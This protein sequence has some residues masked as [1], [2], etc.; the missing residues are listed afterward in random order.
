MNSSALRFV[1]FIGFAWLV[2]FTTCLSS[3]HDLS[4]QSS[5]DADQSWERLRLLFV[6]EAELPA[7]L[8]GPN[9]R[10]VLEAA[11]VAELLEK[12]RR[13]RADAAEKP[14]RDFR[15]Q[16]PDSFVWERA[17]YEVE[18]D[19]EVGRLNGHALGNSFSDGLISLPIPW[20]QGLVHQLVQNGSPPVWHRTADGQV[21]LLL[22]EG[23][24][25]QFQVEMTIPVSSDTVRQTV[26]LHL[27]TV[28]VASLSVRVAG[29]V[30]LV[31]GAAVIDRRYDE[32]DHA[33]Y[34]QLAA[35]SGACELVFTLNNRQ[36]QQTLIWDSRALILADVSRNLDR[37]QIVVE[38]QILQGQLNQ[39]DWQ[40]TEDWEVSQVTGEGVRQWQVIRE[41]QGPRLQVWF[42]NGQATKPFQVF[43]FRQRT[44]SQ[45][46]AWESPTWVAST[47][48][49]QPRVIEITTTDDLLVPR[50]ERT[51][52]D[53]VPASIAANLRQPFQVNNDATLVRHGSWYGTGSDAQVRLTLRAAEDLFTTKSS[54]YMLLSP[55][56]VESRTVF[57][58]E[59]QG[60][61]RFDV[62]LNLP[63]GFRVQS[64][65]DAQ[66]N[67][68]FQTNSN[69]G[70]EISIALRTGIG[71]TVKSLLNDTAEPTVQTS[72]I[73]ELIVQSEW[74]PED[75]FS[76][77]SSRSVT[78]R[79]PY[80]VGSQQTNGILAVGIA[81]AYALKSVDAGTMVGLGRQELVEAELASLE[82]NVAFDLG[83]TA[84][85]LKLELER[86]IATTT[87]QSVAYYQFE[88]TRI[89]VRGEM[90][91]DVRNGT[92]ETFRLQLPSDTPESTLVRCLE[93]LEIRQQTS[94]PDRPGLREIQLSQGAEGRVHLF[95]DYEVPL[96]SENQST[97]K[98]EPLRLED[99][100][101]QT[102]LVS[103]ESNPRL[104]T[105]IETDLPKWS[106]DQLPETLYQPA[107]RL[108]GIWDVT[109]EAVVTVPV[110]VSQQKTEALPSAVIQSRGLFSKLADDG[111][112]VTS[113]R[114]QLKS[115]TG[116]L[117]L[118]LPED[119]T[120]WALRQNGTPQTVQVTDGRVM[121]SFADRTGQLAHDVQFVYSQAQG[122]DRIKKQLDLSP[123][124][125]F[126]EAKGQ[127]SEVP[128][129]R[130]E[131]ELEPPPG[132][133]LKV[134]PAD[135]SVAEADAMTW[136]QRHGQWL[137]R[138]GRFLSSNV[139]WVMRP[140][141]GFSQESTAMFEWG[142][143]PKSEPTADWSMRAEMD[144]MMERMPPS[145]LA[146][147]KSERSVAGEFDRSDANR[148]Q[149]EAGSDPFGP[150]TPNSPEP[151]MAGLPAPPG[152]AMAGEFSL[153]SG[154]GQQG[155][156]LNPPMVPQSQRGPST[157]MQGF[158]SLEIEAEGDGQELKF[159]GLGNKN[160]L[161]VQL[162]D[163]TWLDLLTFV[164]G[165][166]AFAAGLMFGR[167]SFRVW[168]GWAALLLLLSAAAQWLW[169]S[170]PEV[171][172]IVERMVWVVVLLVLW[173]LA[174]SIIRW[175]VSGIVTM[176]GGFLRFYTRSATASSAACWLLLTIGTSV[177]FGQSFLD[178]QPGVHPLTVPDDAIVIPYDPALPQ[179]RFQGRWFVPKIWFDQVREWESAKPTAKI[180]FP[181][182]LILPGGQYELVVANGEA[183]EI[184]AVCALN[185]P[186]EQMTYLPLQFG[187]GAL[188]TATVDG[189]PV[190]I[191]DG[192][193]GA[194][195]PAELATGEKW[196]M[197]PGSG[198][199]KLEFRVRF[200]LT[201]GP[202][203]WQA[204]GKL[205]ATVAA[206]VTFT[207]LPAASRLTWSAGGMSRVWTV[208]EDGTVSPLGVGPD[209]QFSV[210]WRAAENQV[211]VGSAAISH[212]AE[213]AVRESGVQ[214]ASR[215]EVQTVEPT[216]ELV[217]EV[218]DKWRVERIE[219]ANLRAWNPVDGQPGQILLQF[220]ASGTKQEF[221]S[222]V[223]GEQTFWNTE[224]EAVQ[225]PLAKVKA[226][227]QLS[228]SVKIFRAGSLQVAATEVAGLR[229]SNLAESESR[230]VPWLSWQAEFFGLQP[231]Q[232][233]TWQTGEP[234][235]VLSVTRVSPASKVTHRTVL[236]F[237][238]A[239]TSFETQVTFERSTTPVSN[240]VLQLPKSLKPQSLTC[241]ARKGTELSA[242]AFQVAKRPG[243]AASMDEYE[244]RLADFQS[245]E[246]LVT[247][248]G[249][250][251]STLD[252]A[253]VWE[254]I[255]VL[256]AT[257][258]EYE[259]AV[260]RTDTVE[261]TL[262]N[263]TGADQVLPDEFKTW[264]DPT[265]IAQ[266]P[267]SLRAR[268][269]EHRFEVTN[270]RLPS[271]VSF[272]SVTDLTIGDRVI[273]ETLLLEWKIERSGINQVE[274]LLPKAWQNCQIEGPWIGRIE[275]NAADND[276]IR[277]IVFLQD[278]I[279]GD[280]RLLATLDRPVL[281][282]DRFATIPQNLTGETRNRWITA[283][284]SG[285]LEL[286]LMPRQDVS[287]IQRQRSIFTDLQ[288]K[289]NATYLA[290]AFTVEPNAVAPQLEWR[291]VPRA[292][293]ETRS[294]RVRLSE[295]DLVVD[296][297]G[298][299]LAKQRLQVSNRT[300]PKLQLQLPK[301]SQLI[302]L[303]VDG[304]P[305]QPLANPG[306][307]NGAVLIPLLKS[308]ELNL[309]YPIDLIYQGKI[310]A[311]SI[312]R[313][314]SLP[315][316]YTMDVESE[317]SHLRLYLS[318]D[319][320]P[321]RFGGTMSRVNE[322]RMLRE[323][324]LDYRVNQLSEFKKMIGKGNASLAQS[325]RQKS[326]LESYLVNNGLV[327]TTNPQVLATEIDELNKVLTEN[328]PQTA[329][330]FS[331][332]SNIRGLVAQQQNSN[333]V[334]L[335][336]DYNF[337]FHN[338][339]GEMQQQIEL[340][341][342]EQRNSNQ[343][344]EKS[345][346]NVTN[347]LLSQAYQSDE[348]LQTRS[349]TK[350][351]PAQQMLGSGERQGRGVPA[352]RRGPI[353]AGSGESIRDELGQNNASAPP[354]Q[355]AQTNAPTQAGGVGGLSNA[356]LPN[357]AATARLSS[358][359]IVDFEPSGDAY[360]FRVPRGKPELT[361]S[362]TNQ[363]T[364]NSFISM[365]QLLGSA[366]VCWGL[367]MLSKF[368]RPQL[369]NR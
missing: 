237:D 222:I 367:M 299:Y 152:E 45:D 58:I 68:E 243:I 22:T 343:M 120:L 73:V 210:R 201:R 49:R 266:L 156:G 303:I 146:E 331:N 254:S 291:T 219:G 317:V 247:I 169:D 160:Q 357:G 272:E 86:R 305:V 44:F 334:N 9:Q 134:A 175:F 24:K 91:V 60:E 285:N 185:L 83:G 202:G 200:P 53:M 259:Y 309:D 149:E 173:K 315:L 364:Q 244:L 232:A 292:V 48:Y 92:Q 32:T 213:I 142:P 15:L 282:T 25:H 250:L 99:A 287:P 304:Q 289:I 332:R 180:Q 181:Q 347:S 253:T 242:V 82:P 6:P 63:R 366:M 84:G 166:F 115:T 345:K 330:P 161:S 278:R 107:R 128:V 61:L 238:V 37:V 20:K 235:L 54:H 35:G 338:P 295:T 227:G 275:R 290:N 183:L 151:Q 39:A 323:E 296:R 199:K 145:I 353:V 19:G 94:V 276:Q 365:W 46:M 216:D 257:A 137:E 8:E 328:T 117:W 28:A 133:Q 89:V 354:L 129:V 241:L 90:I 214:V 101:W 297:E 41:D 188:T 109:N 4:A 316:A 223:A 301:D 344:V 229:R 59:N 93:P 139:A 280:Y 350:R 326:E 192:R 246:L 67:L 281:Q 239:R 172:T 363:E 1:R 116:N 74:V 132:L 233:F 100:A 346:G 336:K 355:M 23:G 226:D 77:W 362:W 293:V 230:L 155:L 164:I 339:L 319:L 196:L 176:V 194:P 191:L 329:N 42:H 249:A 314:V 30:D 368:I 308:S 56:G 118:Q 112:L 78:L 240:I 87:G 126:F 197:I 286:E 203:G 33:T 348:G 138:Q 38:N 184:S 114:F 144:D 302:Q 178:D 228:G 174:T 325:L 157:N 3:P 313:E 167:N 96:S 265:R 171:A 71:G 306:G 251:D 279:V 198:E 162:I 88:P 150:P 85:E 359:L 141:N 11:E 337:N 154:S 267:I 130:T 258:Q 335:N 16:G 311:G 121:I 18:L 159:V 307:V 284:N 113:A 360:Y 7:V 105:R 97:L 351:A 255:R 27:P 163:Q 300:Q 80:V 95:V 34:F 209:G 211:R 264:L 136:F 179:N 153:P 31:S 72:S 143:R 204:E 168:L 318:P 13:Q 190:T 170:F 125:W 312:L 103:V 225:I 245:D 21:A 220:L 62:R 76:D 17:S 342:L 252:T 177:S 207:K 212:A 269:P 50:I 333:E 288:K 131:W 98:L 193:N 111:T 298:N 165:S 81:P 205:P 12:L 310:E 341:D 231:Y 206:N 110:A 270:R 108:V 119:S 106:V 277:F 271:M 65:A 43:A 187:E 10:V 340:G 52:M 261:L 189:E 55:I 36:K 218:P 57:Q 358:G 69:E 294:A 2:M 327:E 356:N 104:E 158:R 361:V 256:N 208:P 352:Q 64:V 248:Q 147:P 140:M 263:L 320:R 47:A 321:L 349:G 102:Q 14:P 236:H 224:S 148:D 268:G 260:T 182:Q 324:V 262:T 70:V 75:W 79:P 221:Q 123:P 217:L 122:Y 127:A 195:L 273:E 274:F 215:F 51:R 5:I 234:N 186:A 124:Q 66:G 369:R 29:N 26:Q 135:W 40:L 283:Q 322:E